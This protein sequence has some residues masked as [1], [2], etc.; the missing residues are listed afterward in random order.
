MSTGRLWFQL[1]LSTGIVLMFVA[2]GL[3]WVNLFW[4]EA[5]VVDLNYPYRVVGFPACFLVATNSGQTHFQPIE[6]LIDCGLAFAV[7][8]Y[9]GYVSERFLRSREAR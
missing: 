1:H 5:S 2:S 3:V 8:G 4:I 6:F 7:L 9:I